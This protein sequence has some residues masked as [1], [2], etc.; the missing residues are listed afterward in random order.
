[1]IG[2]NNAIVVYNFASVG[3]IDTNQLMDKTREGRV[4]NQTNGGWA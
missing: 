4:G 2:H 1:M 3:H